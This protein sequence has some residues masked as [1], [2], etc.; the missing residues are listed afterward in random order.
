M[1]ALS[2][3][4]DDPTGPAD[5]QGNPAKWTSVRKPVSLPIRHDLLLKFPGV[6]PLNADV[7]NAGCFWISSTTE[8]LRG[9]VLNI[10]AA[11]QNSNTLNL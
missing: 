8:P 1:I 4:Q 2:M 11:T 10:R 7:M 6:V 5:E 9:S 3:P